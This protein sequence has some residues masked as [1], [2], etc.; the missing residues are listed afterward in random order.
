MKEKYAKF[1]EELREVREDIQ[2]LE[3]AHDEMCVRYPAVL[4]N[5][6]K[7]FI[8]MEDT[9]HMKK[10]ELEEIISRQKALHKYPMLQLNITTM[11]FT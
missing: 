2:K 5:A 9:I 10:T 8:R 4:R 11:H 7:I 1:E 3:L 6:M